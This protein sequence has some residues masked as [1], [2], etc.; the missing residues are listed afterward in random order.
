MINTR[1]LN[2]KEIKHFLKAHGKY[3]A[4]LRFYIQ[5]IP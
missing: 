4:E 2:L 5:S 1:K 3:V